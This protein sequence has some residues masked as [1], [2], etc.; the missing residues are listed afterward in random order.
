MTGPTKDRHAPPRE[1]AAAAGRSS[2]RHLQ[3]RRRCMM[4]QTIFERTY[5]GKQSEQGGLGNVRTALCMLHQGISQHFGHQST[6]RDG[7]GTEPGHQ[8]AT[9]HLR[10]SSRILI[11][12]SYCA[13]VYPRAGAHNGPTLEN[14]E[15]HRSMVCQGAVI[16]V[17]RSLGN[18]TSRSCSENTT[19]GVVDRPQTSRADGAVA[20]RERKLPPD[21]ETGRSRRPHNK[22]STRPVNTEKLLF[23]SPL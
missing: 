12:Q 1:L 5:N 23:T 19:I 14:I 7:N 8:A 22:G 17:G 9:G 15:L 13:T 3:W 10:R 4:R 11:G 2:R 16:A 20:R 18:P 6:V 21:A